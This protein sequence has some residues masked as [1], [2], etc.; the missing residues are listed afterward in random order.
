AG[1]LQQQQ[2]GLLLPSI[3]VM[4]RP[5][6]IPLSFSQE[7]LWFIDQLEGSVQYHVPFVLRLKGDLDINALKYAFENILERHQVLRTVFMQENGQAYQSI[8]DKDG[9]HLNVI[10]ATKLKGKENDLALLKKQLLNK[11]FDLSKDYM[12]RADLLKLDQQ[13]HILAVALHHIAADGWS[14]SII[15]NEI[16]ELYSAFAERRPVNL[17]PLPF[18]YADFAIWQRHYIDGDV[19]NKKMAYWKKQLEAVP[20]LQLPLDFSRPAIWSTNGATSSFQIDKELLSGLNKLSQQQG[21]TLFMVLLATFKVL[22]H[23]YSGQQDICV[24]TPIAGRQQQELEGLIGFFV[25]TLALRTTVSGDESFTS[26]LRQVQSVTMEAYENQE[27]PFERIVD[28]VVKERSLGRNPL[29]QVMMVFMNTPDVPQLRFG[30]MQ[31]SVERFENTTAKFDIQMFLSGTPDGLAMVTEYCTDLFTAAT[32]NRMMAHFGELLAAVVNE[33]TQKISSLSMLTPQEE[34]HLVVELNN[35]KAVY[36]KDKNVV[37]LFEQQVLKTPDAIAIIVDDGQF[38]YR[39]LNGHAN[40]LAHYLRSHGAKEETLVPICLS[41]SLQM[42]VAIWGI[43]KAGAAYVPIDPEYP[44]ERISYMLEDT[45]A[46]MVV[47]SRQSSNKIPGAES[48]DIIELDDFFSVINN[49]LTTNPG[50]VI[51]ASQLA[52]VIYTSGSTGNPKGVMNEHGGIANRLQWGQDYFKLTADDVVLQKTTFCFDVSI[53]ELLWASLVGAKIVFAQPGGQRDN[54]YLKSV[55]DRNKVSVIHFVPS[56]LAVF[57][58]DLQQGDC[59]S[60][61]KV[62]CS[63]EALKASHVELVKQKLP[64]VELHNLYGPTEAAIEVT[65]WSMSDGQHD[66]SIIPIGK[67]VA[68]TPI[69]IL[70]AGGQLAPFGGIGEIH[71]GGI[72]V[73][74]GYLNLPV[75]T[76]EKFITDNYTKQSFS[77]LY[78]TG[79][80]GRWMA[81]GNIEYQ[82]RIDDQVKVRG[83]R[84]ELG[85]IESVLHQSESVNQAVVLAKMDKAGNTRLISYYVPSLEIVKAK[86]RELYLD[87]VENWKDLYD[88][89][90]AKTEENIDEEFNLIGW[91]SSFTGEA[92]P[93]TQMRQWV[94]DIVSVIL[95][96][97]P[98]N[99]L[100]IGCGTGLIYYPLA[101]K[102]KKYTGTDLSKTSIGQ[103]AD[104]ISKGERDYGSTELKVCAAHEVVLPEGEQVD[105]IILNSI[106][107]YFPGVEYMDTVMEKSIGLLNGEGRIVIGDVRDYRLLALFRGRLQMQTM[108]HSVDISEFKWAVEQEVL[109]ENE[110]CIDPLYFFRLKNIYPEITHVEIHWKHA[111]YINELSLYRYTVVIHVGNKNK[112]VQPKWQ[113]WQNGEGENDII[114]QIK[115]KQDLIAIKD[116]PNPRLSKEIF[117]NNALQNEL[118]DSVGILHNDSEDAATKHITSVLDLA[119]A[120]G[121]NYK[122]LLH[123]DP[124]KV[125]IILS[126]GP[127]DSFFQQPHE[128]QNNGSIN[129]LT[130]IPLFTDISWQLQ[131]DLKLMLHQKLPDYMVPSEMIALNHIPLTS[132]GKVDRKFLSQREEKSIINAGNYLPPSTVIEHLLV[133]IWKELLGIDQVGIEDNF[134]E[135]GGDSILTIQIV[136]RLRRVGYELQPKDVFI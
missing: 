61:T 103:I 40:Q 88:T 30:D 133:T 3:E 132:N 43:L 60:L 21:S 118:V 44:A 113:N 121:Y 27:V 99:V 104:R 2:T 15:V 26:F 57:L 24:G 129:H 28:E 101:G 74:R 117:L 126:K 86:E 56:M 51:E 71:I 38:T 54:A 92:I 64:Q 98:G 102:V 62:M 39:Q 47:T 84:I 109:R 76:A 135:M 75:L 35:N 70:D 32:I 41:R 20:P 131:K 59:A 17:A 68:N 125:N 69:Y 46:T 114:D 7:R 63:G 33:P 82:G 130:N 108:S 110:F 85:E 6:H 105:T 122:L 42:I 65:Y 1:H 31:L 16:V 97:Q 18:Q 23:R 80:L 53:W 127:N 34:H 93:A 14:I 124:L 8:I 96:G 52:Y 12:V 115:N 72:Q 79:D 78:K 37:N 134:F 120:N 77:R 116:T 55:I 58:P 50:L 22:L 5:E 4:P 73:A 66:I 83:Y 29:F 123:E 106:V 19:L 94:D 112:I 128:N 107:Q 87:R 111:D 89:E 45:A 100:E 91:N 13:D 10:E 67:P 36:S 48:I 90:Y 95:S 11:P 119:S 25:N 49:Q 81:D 136:S 9:W